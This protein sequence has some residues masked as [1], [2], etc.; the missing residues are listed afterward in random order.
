[1]GTGASVDWEDE[2]S[3]E[4]AEARD[5]HPD[6]YAKSPSITHRLTSLSMTLILCTLFLRIP[7]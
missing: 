6:V 4:V 2:S 3:A 7:L 5:R 1:M